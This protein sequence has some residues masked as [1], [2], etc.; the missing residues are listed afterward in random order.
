MPV[1]SR[2]DTTASCACGSVE[3]A[4]IGAPI[5]SNVCYCGD[6]QQGS[7]QIEALPNAGPVRDPDGGTAYILYPAYRA[8][9]QGDLPPLQMRICTK[10]KAPDVVVSDDVP[11]YP[12]YP[13]RL[14]A[15][16]LASR[17]AML[18]RR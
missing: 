8:R 4:A 14:L 11:S 10:Y 16:F 17:V 5:V 2:I 12:G 6:C 7:R 3:L 15:K 13:L 1:P 9:F 18:L